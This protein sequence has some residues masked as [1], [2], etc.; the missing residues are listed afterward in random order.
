MLFSVWTKRIL[1]SEIHERVMPQER[2]KLCQYLPNSGCLSPLPGRVLDFPAL[3]DILC[4][5][6]EHI[7]LLDLTSQIVH[8]SLIRKRQSLVEID[9]ECTKSL[10]KVARSLH[11]VQGSN[12]FHLL[13]T[14]LS[15]GP[16][17]VSPSTVLSLLDRVPGDFDSS[18]CIVRK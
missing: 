9:H 17:R 7:Y 16:L 4:P 3:N 10:S 11:E 13:S 6:I 8:M 18:V 15:P 12:V 2:R 14:L 1:C 5:S